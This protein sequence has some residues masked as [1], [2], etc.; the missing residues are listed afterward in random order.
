MA[1]K[2]LG[3]DRVITKDWENGDFDSLYVLTLTWH[4]GKATM[5]SRNVKQGLDG[6]DVSCPQTLSQG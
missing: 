1:G 3:E 6:G 2:A 5:L 4:D